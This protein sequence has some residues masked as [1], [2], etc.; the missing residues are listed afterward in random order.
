MISFDKIVKKLLKK[1]WNI[2]LMD[3]IFDILDPDKKSEQKSKLYKILYRLKSEK[4]I[5][6][7]RNSIYLIPDEDDLKLNE[8]D[9]IEKYYFK[10]VKKYITSIAWSEYFISGKKA[11]E[12]NMKDFSSP[13]SL[14]VITRN[15]S[16]KVKLQNREI[17]F[18]TIKNKNANL[19]SKFSKYI[20][21]VSV[22]WVEFRISNIEMSLLE[23]AI[24]S[25]NIEWVDISL[26]SKAIKKYS[27]VLK[28]DHFYEIWSSKYIMAFNRLKEIGKN[29][30]KNFYELM[31]DVIK[32][33]WGLFIWEWLRK[34]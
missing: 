28:K 31:L 26:L 34:I 33:N 23:T 30:D 22:F 12:F 19:Y 11:L 18:K 3:D 17:I 25:D 27:K 1:K 7:L 8:I 9:L 5:L 24:V 2:L 20:T 16:K 21:R 4:I 32:Q 14:V 6:T 15:I 10:L 29:I 13:D